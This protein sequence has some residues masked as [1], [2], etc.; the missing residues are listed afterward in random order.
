MGCKNETGTR[1]FD[2]MI[3]QY[4]INV[5]LMTQLTGGME[6]VENVE[7]WDKHCQNI[8]HGIKAFKG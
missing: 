1:K 8:I 5:T 6:D 2:S 7:V 4:E 3:G